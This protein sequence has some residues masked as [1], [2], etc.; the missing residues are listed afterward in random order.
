MGWGDIIT[1]GG[2]VINDLFQSEGSTAEANSFTTASQLAQQN[3]ALTNTSTKIQETQT[4]RSVFQ[5]EG[6]QMA[7][8]AGA[9][10]T[11]SGSA[12][13][14]LRSTAQQG[15]LA[16]SLVN[17]QGAINEN[18][19]A[20]QAGAY[21]GAAASAKEAAQGNTVGAIAA[22]G[23][24][25]VSNGQSLLSAGKT[26]VSGI[27]SLVGGD[28]VDASVAS[29][30]NALDP[31]GL[32]DAGVSNPLDLTGSAMDQAVSGGAD[33]S[34]QIAA[35][36]IGID[37]SAIAIG[38]DV[39]AADTGIT[40]AVDAISGDVS[41]ALASDAA[42]VAFADGTDLVA[43]EGLDAGLGLGFDSMFGPVG[44][45][46]AIASFIPGVGSV[47]N[48]ITSGVVSAVESVAQGIG[49][50]FGGIGDA[51][52]SVFGSVICTAYYKLGY[53]RYRTWIGDQRYGAQC[54]PVIFRGYYCWGKPIADQILKRPLLARCL[55]PIFEP[56]I[57]EMAAELGIGKSTISGKLS[58]TIFRGISYLVGIMLPKHKEVKHAYKA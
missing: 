38:T 8:V 58:L 4:A 50:V 40:S 22:L 53:I 23:G 24:A 14:L 20:A 6:T 15:A 39:T 35:S 56:T 57:N 9:G 30:A 2:Q 29:A 43:G 18:S 7:D 12:L 48:D 41:D 11:E 54:N 47:I 28:S 13:D 49:D 44:I 36:D 42:D 3:A 52:G 27:Q 10:F 51:I 16:E 5:T 45:G 17:I 33:L 31:G 37:T 34:E 26:V 32:V 1:A 25:L 55:F 19:Y 46:L 21:A